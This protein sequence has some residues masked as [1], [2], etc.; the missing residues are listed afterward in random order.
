MTYDVATD[1]LTIAG[2]I[3]YADDTSAPILCNQVWQLKLFVEGSEWDSL[4]NLPNGV[5]DPVLLN[6]RGTLYVLGGY[7]KLPDKDEDPKSEDSTVNYCWVLGEDD[8]WRGIK[9]L[10]TPLDTLF[11]GGGVI[12]HGILWVFT[13]KQAQQYNE[14]NNEW[15]SNE[16]E[17]FTISK[18]TPIVDP[19]HKICA[20]AYYEKDGVDCVG[21]I[22]YDPENNK[23]TPICKPNL[24]QLEVGAGRFLSLQLLPEDVV[25]ANRSALC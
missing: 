17:D 11:G 14:A 3:I 15:I 21:I 7:T 6:H 4:P 8:V 23:W 13:T 18:C 19:G 22:E 20:I 12:H 10:T 25:K 16:F 5:Y 2:G 24:A 9:D 1:L